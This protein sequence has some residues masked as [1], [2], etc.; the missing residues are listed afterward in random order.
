MVEG[1]LQSNFQIHLHFSVIRFRCFQIVFIFYKAAP[2][3][4]QIFLETV[5]FVGATNL[6]TINLIRKKHHFP[7]G[8]IFIII[9]DSWIQNNNNI[10]TSHTSE[11]NECVYCIRLYELLFGLPSI[12]YQCI[13]ITTSR[14]RRFIHFFDLFPLYNI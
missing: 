6:Q 2:I 7:S 9:I 13:I 11:Y 3:Y 8:I 12:Y 10:P 4:K 14:S 5:F 1:N